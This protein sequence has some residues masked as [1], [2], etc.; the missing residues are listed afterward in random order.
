MIS[1]INVLDETYGEITCDVR[2]WTF[3]AYQ[4][5]AGVQ[6][7]ARRGSKVFEATAPDEHSAL[8]RVAVKVHDANRGTP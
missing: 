3:A 1:F 7:V 6:V 2:G 5:P 4:A 8:C